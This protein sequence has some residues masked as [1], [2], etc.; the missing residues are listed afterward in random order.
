MTVSA[1]PSASVAAGG[2]TNFTLS[3]TPS[4]APGSPYLFNVSIAAN[5]ADENPY[6]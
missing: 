3:I 4:A 1:Q 5:D 2:S 6:D